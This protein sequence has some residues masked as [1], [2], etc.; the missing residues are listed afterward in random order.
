[1]Y[2]A[3]RKV[4]GRLTRNEA[5]EGGPIG[6]LPDLAVGG[7][8]LLVDRGGENDPVWVYDDHPA[9][10]CTVDRWDI[11]R[12]PQLVICGLPRDYR[13]YI[14]ERAVAAMEFGLLDVGADDSELT[15]RRLKV[16][17]VHESWYGTRLLRAAR[18]SYD[19]E[20]PEYRQLI[21]ADETGRFPGEDGFDEELI[22]R[23][24]D[25]GLPRPEHPEDAWKALT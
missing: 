2:D 23:Q 24:P 22:G 19:G 18:E 10:S 16:V 6:R 3:V 11:V 21:W 9:W 7:S 1:M 20:L 4:F 14:I 13:H 17:A 25:L 12:L 5:A 15:S 8:R